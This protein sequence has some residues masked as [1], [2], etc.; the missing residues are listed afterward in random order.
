MLPIHIGQF[1]GPLDLLLHLI[2]K[3]ELDITYL[4]LAAV[5]D[6]YLQQVATLSH[7]GRHLEELADFLVIAAKLILIKSRLLLPQC[8][9]EHSE[10]ED[11]EEQ[12]KIYR[13]FAR[14]AKILESIIRTKNVSFFRPPFTSEKEIVFSP[15]SRV[16]ADTFMRTFATV[17]YHIEVPRELPKSIYFDSRVSIEEKMDQLR[18]MISS[19]VKFYFRSLL[20]NAQSKTEIIVSFLALLELVKQQVVI[21]EQKEMFDDILVSVG[22]GHVSHTSS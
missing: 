7:Q 5:T 14:A 9:D 4:S 20:E 2:E 16:T 18:T 19:H 21:A 11:L 17:L 8:N 10:T 22:G 3:E 1:E 6:Q 12:L 15:P 13:E